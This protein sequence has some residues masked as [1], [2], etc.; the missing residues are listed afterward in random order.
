MQ[1]KIQQIHMQTQYNSVFDMTRLLVLLTATWGQLCSLQTRFY[2]SREWNYSQFA[3]SKQ[4]ESVTCK[5]NINL[6]FVKKKITASSYCIC[7][8][9]PL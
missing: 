1:L 3:V 9:L 8:F 6:V 4:V 2:A 7:Y 5:I